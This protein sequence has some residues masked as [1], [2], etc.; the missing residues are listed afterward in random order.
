M[1]YRDILEGAQALADQAT[2]NGTVWPAEKLGLDKRCGEV[3]VG[4]DW[5][6][7]CDPRRLDYY[8]GFEYIGRE[9]RLTLGDTVFYSI[10]DD[11]VLEAMTILDYKEG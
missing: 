7:T 11:R 8:G 9:Y 3:V 10:E 1:D 4:E 2:K 6:A 5:I